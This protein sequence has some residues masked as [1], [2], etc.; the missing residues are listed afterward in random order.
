MMDRLEKAELIREKTGAS[1]DEAKNAL[2]ACN[3][4]ALDAILYIQALQKI[5]GRIIFTE[6]KL[7]EV[8]VEEPKTKKHTEKKRGSGFG[9]FLLRMLQKSVENKLKVSRHGEDLITVPLLV[10]I[11]GFLFG[12]WFLLPLM[13]VGMCCD[14]SYRLVKDEVGYGYER[15]EKKETL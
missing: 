12:F 2:D 11:L 1:Y 6:R 15:L 10:L 9:A 13:I 4:D 5:D 8:I 7:P 3:G 14:C